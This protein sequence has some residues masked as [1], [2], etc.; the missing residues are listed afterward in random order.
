MELVPKL[1]GI[2]MQVDSY[3]NP[4]THTIHLERSLKAI[5]YF[6][7]KIEVIKRRSSFFDNFDYYT[8]LY[9]LHCIVYT[10]RRTG[11]HCDSLQFWDEFRI[12]HQKLDICLC[13]Y[14][15]T[16]MVCPFRRGGGLALFTAGKPV[17][18]IYEIYSAI[19]PRRGGW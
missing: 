13:L 18:R 16:S 6:F 19:S 10:C 9:T 3:G 4:A 7:I 17:P 1:Q 2:P 12:R 11:L 15:Y 14:K 8:I 5:K